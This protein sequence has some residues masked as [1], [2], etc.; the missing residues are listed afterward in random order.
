MYANV[1][2]LGLSTEVTK[3]DSIG[4]ALA[5]LKKIGIGKNAN[6][7]ITK[8][9]CDFQRRAF[10]ESFRDIDYSNAM[11]VVINYNKNSSVP[12]ISFSLIKGKP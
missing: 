11:Q 5:L 12:P 3:K 7:A 8:F 2:Y 4:V 9:G 10:F 1:S 6:L